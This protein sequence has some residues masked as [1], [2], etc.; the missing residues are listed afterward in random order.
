MPGEKTWQH[1]HG[2]NQTPPAPHGPDGID[3]VGHRQYVGGLWDEIGK[4]QFEFL[5]S[6]GL[7][8]NHVLLDIAC[9]S[10]R[11][12]VHLI[13]YLDRGNYLGVDKEAM[14]IERGL[15]VE[16]PQ[17][18]RE[19][20]VPE[21][22]VSDSFDF[23]RLSKS[24]DFAIAQSLFTH[25]PPRHIRRCLRRLR[26]VAPPDCH[27]YATFFETSESIRNP[28]RP[29]DLMIWYYTRQQ[30][31]AFGTETG[32]SATYLGDWAHPRGQVMVEYRPC[33]NKFRRGRFAV[34]LGG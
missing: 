33:G 32:W 21:V 3:K 22:I 26:E 11:A 10:M 19:A 1:A 14:L 24:P 4:L 7:K 29:H 18:V 2:P 30:M 31:I 20:K 17:D 8:P 23:V 34:R 9:G 28:R 15:A 6:R 13:P 25:L 12:G 27:F 5:V 16:I